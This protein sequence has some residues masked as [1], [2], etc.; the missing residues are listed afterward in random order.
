MKQYN[1][2]SIEIIYTADITTSSPETGFIPFGSGGEGI[3]F[4]SFNKVSLI[5]EAY[6]VEQISYLTPKP[7]EM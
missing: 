2:P 3:S 7:Y 6:D 5:Q 1:S 4:N